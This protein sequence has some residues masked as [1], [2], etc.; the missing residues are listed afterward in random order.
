MEDYK[1]LVSLG[2]ACNVSLFIRSQHSLSTNY[3][4][5]KLGVPMWAVQE[6]FANNFEDFMDAKNIEIKQI[7]DKNEKRFC[8]DS[9]YYTILTN[10]AGDISDK[11]LESIKGFADDG[12]RKL[13]LLLESKDTSVLFIR[14][15]LPRDF[16]DM[17]NLITTGYEDKFAESEYYYTRLLSK[18][19]EKTYPELSFKILTLSTTDD[20]VDEEHRIVNLKAP[21]FDY[22][23]QRINKPTCDFFNQPRVRAFLKEHLKV[24]E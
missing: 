9:K 24:A 16:F 18:H 15:E 4:F 3:V 6:L 11:R 13:D 10:E 19:L 7:F 20:F 14:S 8:V 17:G 5:D 2:Y 1:Y 21:Y 12:K 23:D 22:R